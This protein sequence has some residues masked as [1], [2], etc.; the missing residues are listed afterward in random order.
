SFFLELQ[1]QDQFQPLAQQILDGNLVL[2]SEE[3]RRRIFL[4]AARSAAVKKDLPA[5]ERFMAATAEL[6]GPDTD[7][8]LRSRLAEARGHI[9]TAIQILRDEVDPDS[10]ATLL[11]I[12]ARARGDDAA[13]AWFTDQKLNVYDLT[14]NG[15]STICN[16]HLAKDDYA[17]VKDLLEGLS[18]KHLED[19]PYF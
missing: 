8:P 19:C 14:A 17:R 10:R 18:E 15:I 9:D 4:R 3:L 12:I 1:K 13:L 16:F 5:A 11:S 7:R 6:I 2:L